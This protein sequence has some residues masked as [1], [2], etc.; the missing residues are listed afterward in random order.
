[1]MKRAC[2]GVIVLAAILTGSFSGGCVQA[3]RSFDV[4]I[5]T[6]HSTSRQDGQS[7]G[8]SGSP[9]QLPCENEED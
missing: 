2:I 7:P 8:R 1:M 4:N 3:P 9:T 5:N 6:G